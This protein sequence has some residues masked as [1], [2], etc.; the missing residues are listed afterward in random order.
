MSKKD[1]ILSYLSKVS[2]P[3]SSCKE[4]YQLFLAE[5]QIQVSYESFN[6]HYRAFNSGT[7][8]FIPTTNPGNLMEKETS[9]KLY[10]IED[11]QF[12]DS[13][14]IP[15]KS[16][17]LLDTIVS[18]EGGIMPAT[19]TIVPGVSGVGKT[20]ILL[21]Y[22]GKVK[23]TNPDLRIL[24]VS[25][26]MNQIHLFKY[27]KRIDFS[28]I[29]I[30]VLGDCDENLGGPT[31]ILEKV[32]AEGWDLIVLDSLQDTINK[33]KDLDKISSGEAERFLLSKMDKTRKGDNDSHK[34][35]SFF[36]TQHMTKGEVYAGSTNLKHMTDAMMEIKRDEWN[37]DDTFIEYSKNRDGAIKR[38]LYFAFSS[39]SIEYNI[40]RFNK[41]TEAK[42]EMSE[43]KSLVVKQGNDFDAIFL[44]ETPVSEIITVNS[45]VE[46]LETEVL[47]IV[48]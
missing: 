39:Q 6:D 31:A 16:D 1:L 4:A 5:T 2:T 26:E 37:P 47:E 46:V 21:D 27:G 28:N 42:K 43:I 41:D 17:S 22:L 15:I 33:I 38:R 18:F 25:S 23:R 3:A 24:F 30:L 29:D 11:I 44:G 7:S 12:D 32:F 10:K 8:V 14:L 20:T 13:I 40:E 35:T 36:C 9:Y 48:N 45:E 19:I 34:Y